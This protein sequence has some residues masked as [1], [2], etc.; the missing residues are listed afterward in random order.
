MNSINIGRIKKGDSEHQQ[1]QIDNPYPYKDGDINKWHQASL[2][3]YVPETD[4]YFHI[5][6]MTISPRDND[7][8]GYVSNVWIDTDSKFHVD[9]VEE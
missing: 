4:E 6:N 9:K 2:I 8:Y 7:E 3:L 5:K 1:L